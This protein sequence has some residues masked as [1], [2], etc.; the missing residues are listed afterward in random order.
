MTLPSFLFVTQH[1]P[2]ERGAAQVR[3]G[4]VTRHL[5]DAGHR[6]EVVTAL[7][8][9]PM[10]RIFPGWARRPVQVADEGGIRTIRVWVWA[11]MGSGW[12]RMANYLSFGLM[13][14]VGLAM[15][16]PADWTVV[17]YPTLFG[18]LPAVVW[19]RL[20]G[21]AVAVN[22][23]DLWVD[24][25]AE[26]GA[27]RDGRAMRVLRAVEGWM[28]RQ[29]DVVTAVTEGVGIA[30]IAKGVAPDR[31][32]SL[33]NGADTEM[34]QPGPADPD[35]ARRYDLAPGEHVVLYAGTH[36]YVHGLEVVLD[37]ADRLRDRPIRFLLVGGGSE[38]PALIAAAAARRLDNVRFHDPVAPEEI[39]A[40]LRLSVAGLASVRG[41]EL[42]RSVRSAKA[43]PVM[44][45]G[46]PVIYCGDDEG[47][48]EVAAI[49]AGLVVAP[50]DGPALAAAVVRLIDHPDEAARMGEAGR[51]WVVGHASWP[52][53]VSRWVH[54]LDD[55]GAAI[56]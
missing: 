26:I 25:I 55:S 27:L 17:E 31:L 44:A 40:L 32:L 47:S 29:A 2:P 39:A 36:G 5:A 8:N 19:S 9:Y 45:S 37:A 48:A 54:Q 15:A 49:G 52:A 22:V 20:R 41:A 30:L 51:C 10:G 16:S 56:S 38:K 23:A 33:P 53:L 14:V 35:L 7:P 46:R 11:S 13:S 34:F 42:Y 18:A 24:A 50:G 4:A 1:H 3:L 6:V 12:R 21:R 28:L 43:L